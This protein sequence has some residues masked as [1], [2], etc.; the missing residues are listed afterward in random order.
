M[1]NKADT[2]NLQR[3]KAC[4]RCRYAA[5]LLHRNETYISSQEA[6]D[7]DY[8]P[9]VL[10]SRFVNQLF[11]SDAT[12]PNRPASSV[13]EPRR[14]TLASTMMA[15]ARHGRNFCAR[16]LPAWNTGFTSWRNRA[17]PHTLLSYSPLQCSIAI[18]SHPHH[19][20][21]R[22]ARQGARRSQHR[23]HHFQVCPSH[24]IPPIPFN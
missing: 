14:A 18:Q 9:S 4:L 19:P 20:C 24:R 22:W 7:G 23:N 13:P 17:V 5:D 16:P 10:L 2:G 3:G 1:A 21:L 6:Q 15:R 11:D 12:V 8:T